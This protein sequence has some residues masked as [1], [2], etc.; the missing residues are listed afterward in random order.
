MCIA[1]PIPTAAD[2]LATATPDTWS[3]AGRTS[4]ASP[5]MAAIQ[6]LINQATGERWGNPDPVYYSLAAAEYGNG[7]DSECNS[8]LGNG[9]ASTC[10]FYDVTQGDMDVP[11]TGTVNCYLPSGDVWGFCPTSKLSVSAGLRHASRLGFRHGNRQRQRLQL[12]ASFPDTVAFLQAKYC[13]R[14]PGG[15]FRRGES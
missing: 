14:Q 6:S 10:I 2:L 15:L 3:L 8:T 7:G 11:C 12:R 9:V 4:F 1:I 5:I 13:P